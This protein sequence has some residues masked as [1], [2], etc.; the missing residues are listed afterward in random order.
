MT[1]PLVINTM[2]PAL[3][4]MMPTQTPVELTIPIPS[5]LQI[6]AAHALVLVKQMLQSQRPHLLLFTMTAL[7]TIQLVMHTMIPA[8]N[9]MTKTQT[10]VE[11]TILTLLSLLIFAAPALE[12]VKS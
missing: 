7:M 9:G 2:T 1:I 5:L 8:R 10:H 11:T 12:L 3:S 4:G 6:F